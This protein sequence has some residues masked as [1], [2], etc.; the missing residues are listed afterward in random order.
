MLETFSANAAYFCSNGDIASPKFE[1][2]R[3]PSPEK[4]F[5]SKKAPVSA[6]K[7]RLEKRVSVKSTAPD[8]RV[9]LLTTLA[10]VYKFAFE[11]FGAIR[12]CC[13]IGRDME[14][15][16]MTFLEGIFVLFGN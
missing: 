9:R 11:F 8:H 15:C 4:T 3:A 10:P 1:S 5:W 7:R 12:G 2:R 16:F 6:V 14:R 13:S